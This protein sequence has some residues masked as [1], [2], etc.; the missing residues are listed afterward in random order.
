MMVETEYGAGQPA[1]H[2]TQ[3]LEAL[4]RNCRF[5][6]SIWMHTQGMSVDDATQFFM[7][8]AYM[9][10]LPARREAMRGTFAPGYLSY[11]LGKLMI[12]KLREDFRREQGDAYTLKGFHDR[13][14]SYG[15]PPGASAAAS[16]VEGAGGFGYLDP[17][18]IN[19]VVVR[20]E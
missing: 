8:K 12:L 18:P 10:E 17:T 4:V 2:L 11:T 19:A 6:C 20:D 9:G 14:L 15:A 7:H 3:L 16:H 1:L 5:L 13:L